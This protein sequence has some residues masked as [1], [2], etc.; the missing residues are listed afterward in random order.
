MLGWKF[1]VHLLS[2]R[3]RLLR[4]ISKIHRLYRPYHVLYRMAV[5]GHPIV[6]VCVM[7]G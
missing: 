2:F 4:I 6:C 1:N 3:T 7:C 5:D